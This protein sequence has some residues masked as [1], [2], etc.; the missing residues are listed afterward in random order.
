MSFLL[1][2]FSPLSRWQG[3]IEPPSLPSTLQHVT[4]L[5]TSDN[6]EHKQWNIMGSQYLLGLEKCT[7]S[8][9]I[10][11]EDLGRAEIWWQATGFRMLNALAF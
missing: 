8:V 3:G 11:T 9:K 5:G 10:R 7:Y 1:F 2:L 4:Q 6:Y